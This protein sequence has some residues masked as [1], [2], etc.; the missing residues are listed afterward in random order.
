MVI[1]TS[2]NLKSALNLLDWDHRKWH[3]EDNT[4]DFVEDNH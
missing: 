4:H 1:G 2:N 3:N